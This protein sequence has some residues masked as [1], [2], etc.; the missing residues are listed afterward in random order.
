[1]T[2]NQP[3]ADFREV[4]K[5]FEQEEFLSI[6]N[7][8]ERRELDR[9]RK[10][11][12]LNKGEPL[13]EEGKEPEGVYLVHSGVA[14]LYKM[15]TTGKEQIIRFIIE[16]ELLGYRSLLSGQDLGASATAMDEMVV[17]F[18]PRGLFLKIMKSHPEFSFNLLQLLS[19]Q[20]GKAADSITTLAQ[21]TVRERLAEI[22][23]FLEEKMGTDKDGFIAV[24]LTRE[25]YANLI[26]TATESAIRLI[27]EYKKDEL[28]V[29][30][31]RKIKIINH[32]QVSRM[33]RVLY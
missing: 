32:N 18:I 19:I 6:F 1:M 13:I 2:T 26:G 15:G 20:L 9:E 17:E 28:I 33:A 14:K 31:G 16:G 30:E 25:D 4:F 22:L 10:L 12:K 7:E 27:S 11:F 21:K 8:S 3:M 23:L 24:R 5:L 29:T